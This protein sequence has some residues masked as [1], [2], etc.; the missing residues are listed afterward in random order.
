MFNYYRE[1]TKGVTGRWCIATRSCSHGEQIIQLL[2][3]YNLFVVS[4]RF[5]PK[6][7]ASAATWVQ[8]KKAKPSR[9]KGPGNRGISRGRKYI[10]G[11][12][13]GKHKL[14]EARSRLQLDYISISHRWSTC[15]TRCRVRWAPALDRRHRHYDHGLIEAT[16]FWRVRKIAETPVGIPI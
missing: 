16:F 5:K 13:A 2:R 12:H 3:R 4:T 6:R 14:V 15:I 9:S 1:Y 8:N 11:P 10:H 7:N